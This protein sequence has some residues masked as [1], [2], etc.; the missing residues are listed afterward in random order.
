MWLRAG[1]VLQCTR[2][3]TAYMVSVVVIGD[4]SYQSHRTVSESPQYCGRSI[5]S[6]GRVGIADSELGVVSLW[7]L[8]LRS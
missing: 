6:L 7:F 2:T 8:R 5:L 3:V 1:R 4:N